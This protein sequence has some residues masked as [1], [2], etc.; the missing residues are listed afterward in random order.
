[1][2]AAYELTLQKSYTTAMLEDHIRERLHNIGTFPDRVDVPTLNN[3]RDFF[4][5]LD[6]GIRT[7]II[8]TRLRSKIIITYDG[9]TQKTTSMLKKLSTLLKKIEDKT[10]E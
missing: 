3:I 5:S 1:M 9:N 4:S 8:Q 7:K 10:I 6:P 2:I